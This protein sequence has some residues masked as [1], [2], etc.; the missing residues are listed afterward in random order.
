MNMTSTIEHKPI[1]ISE[2]DALRGIA[3]LGVV[4]YHYT[5]QTSVAP[6]ERVPVNFTFP[7]GEFGVQLF[8]MIS[9][10]V[11]IMTLDRAKDVKE[12]I[13]GR[14]SRLYP[15]YWACLLVTFSI[16]TLFSPQARS[17]S[18]S[19]LLWN[20]TM[21]PHLLAHA[22]L[23]DGVYWTLECELLFYGAMALL[24]KFGA[25]K[26]VNTV[27]LLWMM[28]AR[29]VAFVLCHNN[30]GSLPFVLAGKLQTIAVLQFIHYFS[31]GVVLYDV[32]RCQ[33]WKLEHGLVL[34]MAIFSIFGSEPPL[35]AFIV[36]GL[37]LLCWAATA[38]HLP[39]LK[40]APLSFLGGI[41]YT[42]YLLHQNLGHLVLKFLARHDW[43]P[44]VAL[45]TTMLLMILLAFVVSVSVERPAMRWLR[46]RFR[47]RQSALLVSGTSEPA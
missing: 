13:Q 25:L 6:A 38:G 36:V 37:A 43:S 35:R 42:L 39:I 5:M 11:I 19:D 31:I 40:W 26:R 21:L 41:S 2:L 14:F 47:K 46:N 16:L 3:A 9:G 17:I 29:V 22:G 18:V 27:M 23:V 45:I 12:F 33:H 8:F 4:L 1:R 44:F 24:F 32:R 10:F 15:A 7:C 20:F 28:L 30:V 34:A